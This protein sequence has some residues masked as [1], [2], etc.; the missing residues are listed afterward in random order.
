VINYLNGDKEKFL[1]FFHRIHLTKPVH[2]RNDGHF[3]RIELAN[4][5]L[6]ENHRKKIAD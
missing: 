3:E 6:I 2:C 5:L 4:Q 1:P